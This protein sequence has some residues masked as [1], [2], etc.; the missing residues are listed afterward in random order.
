MANSFS[1]TFPEVFSKLALKNF[2]LNSVMSRLVNRDYEGEIKKAGDTVNAIL[3]GDVTVGDYTPGSDVSV[4][5]WSLTNNQ[6][7]ID[8]KKTFNGV[9]DLVEITQSHLS[10]V[11]G[12]M[13]RAS[14][15]MSETVDDRLLGHYADVDAGNV[16]GSNASPIT[17]TAA[18]V[19][20]YF[21][22]AGKMLDADGIPEAGRVAVI[23]EDTKALIRKSDEYTHATSV[24]DENIKK[25]RVGEFAGFDVYMTPRIPTVTPSGTDLKNLMFFT[26]DFISLAFQI[27]A[28]HMKT[29][30]PEKQF[31]TGI[32]GLALYGT[33]VFHST[34]GVVLKRVA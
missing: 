6:M 21:V 16:I 1:S 7:L 33:E 28:D 32:K 5:N 24:G 14:V 12:W 3:Y 23:D 20:D 9:I 30:E 2:D 17:L 15:A 27:P 10:L 34:A 18:N 19:Y 25:G 26:K 22:D 29:Y 8:Q 31:G 4:Q 11:N 13:K